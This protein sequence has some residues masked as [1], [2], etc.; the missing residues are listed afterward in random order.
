MKNKKSLLDLVLIIL[1]QILLSL[2]AVPFV[3]IGFYIH[4]W[5]GFILTVSIIF[6]VIDNIVD[7]VL[8]E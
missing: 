1:E 7:K 8:E 4:Y 6:I 2:I 3:M 5:V